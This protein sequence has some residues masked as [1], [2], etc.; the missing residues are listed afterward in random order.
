MGGAPQPPEDQH[1]D[2]QEH[3]RG[4]SE[5]DCEGCGFLGSCEVHLSK[6][7]R[8]CWFALPSRKDLCIV[9]LNAKGQANEVAECKNDPQRACQVQQTSAQAS[10]CPDGRVR[11]FPNGGLL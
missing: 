4:Q 2:H 3:Q 1:T 6:R 5:D 11:F 7:T 10:A 8:Y 9:H